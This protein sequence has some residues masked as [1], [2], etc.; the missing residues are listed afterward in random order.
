MKV[1]KEGLI[2]DELGRPLF[3]RGGVDS[4]VFMQAMAVLGVGGAAAAGL[5]K[6]FQ[7]DDEGAFQIGTTVAALGAVGITK[8]FKGL[9]EAQLIKGITEGKQGA[10][11]ELYN[12]THRQLERSLYSFERS[13]V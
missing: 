11:T 4:R 8:S 2:V 13:G 10:F 3:Q 12:Q 1:D 5:M 9:P 6:Y 7:G